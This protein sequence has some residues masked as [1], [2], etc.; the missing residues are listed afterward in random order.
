MSAPVASETR[1][2]LSASKE[3]ERV[4]GGRAEPGSDQ[5]GAEL[6]AVQGGGVRLIIQ[7]RPAHVRGRGVVEELFLHGVLV[8]TGDGAQPPGDGG[9]GAAAC[10]QLTGE[11]FDVR[12]A[13]REQRQRAE[14]APG[15]ELAQVQGVGLAGQAAV[16]GEV[17]GEGE[18]FGVG[19]GRLEVARAV[20][21]VVV[22]IGHLPVGLRP[23]SWASPRPQ[24]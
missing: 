1:T 12:A 6:V 5:E 22:V 8:E 19:E 17:S 10:F 15:G 2:P 18:P 7:P 24:R 16:A 14:A 20:D 21:G 4:L 3:I 23:G 9:A 11:R 13:D